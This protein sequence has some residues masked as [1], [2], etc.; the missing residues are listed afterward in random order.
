MGKARSTRPPP[1]KQTIIDPLYPRTL[2]YRPD[3]RR[4]RVYP[5][6]INMMMLL[7]RACVVTNSSSIKG[8]TGAKMVR[9][10]KFV[11]QRSQIKERR[12]SPLPLSEEN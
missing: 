3:S 5:R 2:A 9:D 11:N 6:A 10:V 1:K 7:A 12:S 4:E 8:S